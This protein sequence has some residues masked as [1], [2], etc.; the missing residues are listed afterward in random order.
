MSSV[1]DIYWRYVISATNCLWSSLRAESDDVEREKRS[2][3][4][5]VDLTAPRRLSDAES[6]PLAGGA[7]MKYCVSS[8][9]KSQAS[10]RFQT[11]NWPLS[12]K[13]MSS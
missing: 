2:E 7:V 1:L 6:D 12:M 3:D 11:P 5:D 4:S 10:L 9:R 8:S 13:N